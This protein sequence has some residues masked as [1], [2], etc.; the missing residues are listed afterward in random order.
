MRTDLWRTLVVLALLVALSVVGCSSGPKLVPVM[1]TLK[2]NGKPLD[3]IMVEFIPEAKTG[4]RL[5]ATTDTNGQFTLRC[6]DQRL[7]A[8]IGTHT[9][10]L[11]DLAIFGGKRWSRADFTKAGPMNGPDIKK[12]R[13]PD[14]YGHLPQTPLKK[15]EVKPQDQT[16]DLEVK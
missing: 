4:L 2:Q 6:D 13:I 3:Q 7:G 14:H 12:S 16:I 9:V 5:T 15:I 1:G 10:V 8:E 11:H